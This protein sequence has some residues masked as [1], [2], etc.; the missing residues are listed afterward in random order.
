MKVTIITAVLNSAKTLE[1][2]IKSVLAQHYQNIEYI[3]IDGAST[4][5]SAEI[6]KFYAGIGCR[7][8]SEKDCGFYDGL[9]K[10]IELATGEIIGILNADDIYATQDVIADV[11]NEFKHDDRLDCVYGDLNYI[12]LKGDQQVI[13]RRWVSGPFKCPK[14]Y[15]GWMPPH[16][17]VFLKKHI[18]EKV[19]GFDS[20]FKI[21]ADYDFIL[22]SFKN[23]D[24]RTK[25]MSKLMVNMQIGGVSNRS[26]KNIYIKMLEDYR[27][28]KQ[29]G[30]PGI[31]TLGFKNILKIQQ[32]EKLH[33][34]KRR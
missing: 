15:F 21:S 10:G 22:R 2:T 31:T 1:K 11:V 12:Q 33:F 18:Y 27:V 23:K 6:A 29:N 24:F 30:L 32:I 4:D 14:L 13:F 19:G 3:I 8:V 16:P 7:V 5:G 26:L 34:F 17:T 28:I 20:R 9:N 25:Y